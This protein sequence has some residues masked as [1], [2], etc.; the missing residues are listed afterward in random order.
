MTT[1]RVGGW[2]T[3][4]VLTGVTDDWDLHLHEDV[5]SLAAG[6]EGSPAGNNSRIATF[7]LFALIG[8]LDGAHRSGSQSFVDI[9]I[10]RYGRKASHL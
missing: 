1:V 6:R 8:K 9:F 5:G 4:K 10:K 3:L 7:V 2:G